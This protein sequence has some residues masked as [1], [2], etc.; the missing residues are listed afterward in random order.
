MKFYESN[1]KKEIYDFY[2]TSDD[3]FLDVVT[4]IIER[5]DDFNSEDDIYSAYNDG[6]IY[7]KD[8]WTVYR[9]FASSPDVMTYEEAETLF[10]ESILSLAS[11]IAEKEK[12]E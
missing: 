6:F 10:M 8:Y 1:Y 9:F 5:I 2:Q 11:I 12:E 7:T 3:Y 4:D